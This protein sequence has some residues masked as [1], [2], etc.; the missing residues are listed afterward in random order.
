MRSS[1]GSAYRKFI[2]RPMDFMLSLIAIIVLSPVFLIVA[3]LVKT[4]LGSPVLFKQERRGLHGNIF[5]MYKFRTMT[6]EKDELLPDGVRLT[7]FGKFLRSTSLDELPGLLNIFKGDMSI[8]GP[9]PLL[10]Q[11]LPL[12]NEHQKRRHEVRPGLS[13][14]AQVN[15][16]NAISWEDKFNYDVEYVDN[17]S[18]ITDWKIIFLTLKKVFIRE[19]INSETAATMEPFKGSSKG[20]VEL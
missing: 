8:I 11:Y 4:K 13:G 20:R 17:V 19:G 5:K 12:Y 18:F 10:V 2:K 1:K 14:L 16:R 6:D 7:K 15:G 9:R 3:F